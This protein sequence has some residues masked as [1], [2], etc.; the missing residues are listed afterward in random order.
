MLDFN[1]HAHTYQ[2]NGAGHLWNSAAHDGV[3]TLWL[4]PGY[5]KTMIVLH[6]FKALYDAG[7]AKTM[8][9]VAPLR[10]AQTVWVQEIEEW[11]SLKGLVACFLHGPKK[12][13]ML[14]RRD[15]NIWVINYEG[16][17]WLIQKAKSGR[18]GILDVICFDEIRR[19]KNSQG[20]RF[21]AARPLTKMAKYRWG[22]TG[23]PASNGLMDLFGQF[24]ILDDGEAL[25]KYITK[26]R[27][28]YF[29]QGFDGFTW[30]PRPGAQ[31]LIEDRIK[32]YIYR[33][34]GF[35]DLPEFVSDVRKIVMPKDGV[36]QYRHLK[37][38]MI[39]EFTGEDG[40][41]TVPN[42]AVL[43]GK[44]KQM[45][46]GRVYNE[47]GDVVEV[48]SAKK[49]ALH[50]LIEELGDEQLLI[51]YEY[52]HELDQIREVLGADIPYLGAGVSNKKAQEYVDKWNSGEIPVLAAHPASAGHGLNLQKGGAHHI[53]WWGPTI[54]LDFYIQ[55]NRRLLRQGNTASHVVVHTF[56]TVGTVD[57]SVIDA[58]EDKDGLQAGLLSAL[59]AEF[60]DAIVVNDTNQ[61]EDLS[62][63]EL[64]FQPDAFASA[65]AQPAQPVATPQPAPAGDNPFAAMAAATPQPAPAPQ[66][67]PVEQ[68]TAIQQDVAAPPMPQPAPQPAP[69]P[70]PVFEPPAAP[71]VVE[72]PAP[73]PAAPE[74]SI[75]V[76]PL[77]ATGM[78]P[79]YVH[80]PADKL[81]KVMSA[82]G[83]AVK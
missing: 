19:M 23:T 15:V 9:V 53:L 37:K 45:A 13:K 32:H 77:P 41:I 59:T 56:V 67:A 25:G 17:P 61:T 63:S 64:V 62:M 57:E 69:A 5:G 48:H 1:T 18:L 20:K 10:V 4:D 55:F 40:K 3:A 43:F 8:L 82:V 49:E 2:R 81:D 60:G 75:D 24:L 11:A 54:D 30:H 46:G 26:Y 79:L 74:T 51:A 28:A 47:D 58:R 29:E 68:M 65:P 38:N 44:L 76:L 39:V 21:K 27:M 34:D 42:A 12:D 14:E 70:A 80:V 73:Q 66:P 36:E 35:L 50:D 83:R 72:Q 22:L 16:I 71:E 6:A 31:D 78:V 33:A 7:L 52:N